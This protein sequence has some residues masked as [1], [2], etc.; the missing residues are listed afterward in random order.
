MVTVACLLVAGWL[1][2]RGGASPAGW[3]AAGA[4]GGGT[5][6]LHLLAAL[7]AVDP[8]PLAFGAAFAW[9]AAALV[10]VPALTVLLRRTAV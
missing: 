8:P 6:V 2:V 10:L 7:G 5:L 4:V 1:A 9:V 3:L